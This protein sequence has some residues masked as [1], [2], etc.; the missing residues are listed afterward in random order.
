MP[1]RIAPEI[2]QKV[3]T[4]FYEVAEHVRV[5]LKLKSHTSCARCFEIM[6]TRQQNTRL[7]SG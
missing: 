6:Y 7:Q 1:E 5:N 4:K 2:L 3:I